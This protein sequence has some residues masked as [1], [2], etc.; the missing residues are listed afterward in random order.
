M[1]N[2]PEDMPDLNPGNF[3]GNFEMSW[4]N[5]IEKILEVPDVEDMAQVII[6]GNFRNERQLNAILRLSHR[7]EKFGQTKHQELLRQKIAGT[8]A[9]G[10]LSRV[11]GLFAAIGLLASDI[12]RA[13]KGLP[14]VKEDKVYRGSDFR[15]QERPPEGTERPR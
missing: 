7:H 9:L 4:A 1:T 8:A 11:E 2:T 15:T 3:G 10:G 14:K 6:R 13:A 12:Y 5:R